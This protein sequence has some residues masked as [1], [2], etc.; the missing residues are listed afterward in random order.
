MDANTNITNLYHRFLDQTATPEEITLLLAYFDQSSEED[1]MALIHAEMAQPTTADV[2]EV[3]LALARIH[4]QVKS[5]IKKPVLEGKPVKLRRLW[6][7]YAAAI[8]LALT[9]GGYWY[10]FRAPSGKLP[11]SASISNDITP[12]GNRAYISLSNGQRIALDSTQSGLSSLNG[13]H[14][15]ADGEELLDAAEADY[16]TVSTPLGGT[17]EVTLPDGTKAWLNAQS[18]VRYP[19]RFSGDERQVEIT[20]EVYLEVAR[21]KSHPFIVTCGTQR[22]EVLGTA[23][24]VRTY[25]NAI[26]TTLVHGEIAL[27]NQ[28]TH[29]RVLL[30][31]G[32]QASTT[33]GKIKITEVNPSEYTAWMGGIIYANDLSLV[34]FCQELERWYGVHFVFPA[35]Y[36]N[37][38]TALIS[39]DRREMLS[40]VLAALEKA[41]LVKLTLKGKEVHVQ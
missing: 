31:P 35:G 34:D 27:S 29:E 30:K 38:E 22:I 18:A 1:L 9:F 15:Y 25:G 7:P 24:N 2:P 4:T 21:D 17:Y 12:G 36:D 28:S 10:I 26:I 40:T 13:K 32:D 39:V 19:I 14:R 5:R 3:E 41:Y 33:T 37:K 16:A 6:L 11:S 8:L 23:F 20:G